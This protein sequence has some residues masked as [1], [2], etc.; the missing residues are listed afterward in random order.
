MTEV[1]DEMRASDLYMKVSEAH[2]LTV[3]SQAATHQSCGF[4]YAQQMIVDGI[5]VE[6]KIV[7]K[8]YPFQRGWYD[9]SYEVRQ[10]VVAA[11]V[12]Y[13]TFTDDDYFLCAHEDANYLTADNCYLFTLE[14]LKQ[15]G[16]LRYYRTLNGKKYRNFEYLKN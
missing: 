7:V 9:R 6:C 15:I 13:D 5:R 12:R 14:C 8:A 2:A 11:D 16:R 10:C 1:T 3:L 4:R